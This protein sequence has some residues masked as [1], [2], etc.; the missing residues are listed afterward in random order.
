MGDSDTPL[1]F[2][3][4]ARAGVPVPGLACPNLSKASLLGMSQVAFLTSSF[5]SPGHT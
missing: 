2:L 1:F 4:P 3:F 5:M